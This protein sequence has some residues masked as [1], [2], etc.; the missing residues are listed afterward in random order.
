[1]NLLTECSGFESSKTEQYEGEGASQNDFFELEVES[2]GFTGK[3]DDECEL[4]ITRLAFLP[5]QEARRV[6]YQTYILESNGR[7]PINLNPYDFPCQSRKK[8]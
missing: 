6:Q 2:R 8:S 1:V 4:L 3:L 7:M 5:S